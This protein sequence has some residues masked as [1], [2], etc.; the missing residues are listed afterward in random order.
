MAM[1]TCLSMTLLSMSM[2]ASREVLKSGMESR[3]W[4]MGDLASSVCISSVNLSHS[5]LCQL[6]HVAG[7]VQVGEMSRMVTIR[8]WSV[9]TG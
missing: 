8:R 1:G 6:Y 7:S 2:K 9:H 3:T 5:T 4:E